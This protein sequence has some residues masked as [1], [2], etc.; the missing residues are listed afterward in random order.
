MIQTIYPEIETL[1]PHSH[2]MILLDRIILQDDTLII[3]ELKI[4]S[5]SFL[6]DADLD[7]VP[8]QVG[9]EYMAQ[10]IAALG[11]L[12]A[13]SIGDKPPIGF[14]LGSR[15]YKHEGGCFINGHCY[16]VR[17]GELMRD[18]NMAVYQCQI[19]DENQCI[20]ASGQV[21]TVVA[22]DSMLKA[23]TDNN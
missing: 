23:I 17:A 15:R 6:F 19:F 21:N 2:P 16:Q 12:E 13:I 8:A 1:L 22:S 4:T 3:S 18:D 7:G 20:I 11:G 9:I 5:K 10:T 14:L